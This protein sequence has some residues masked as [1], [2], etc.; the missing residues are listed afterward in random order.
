[1]GDGGAIDADADA[2]G[3]ML[4]D[5]DTELEGERDGDADALAETDGLRELD[6]D[7]EGDVE[8]EAEIDPLLLALSDAD[9]DADGLSEWLGEVEAE[10]ELETFRRPGRVTSATRR[11]SNFVASTCDGNAP[12]SVSAK[13]EKTIWRRCPRGM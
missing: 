1:M 6:G 12:V 4:D 11:P 9:A 2:D 10:A 8:A 3:L 7:R 13:H 5:G